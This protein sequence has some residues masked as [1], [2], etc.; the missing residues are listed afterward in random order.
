MEANKLPSVSVAVFRNGHIDWEESFGWADR[1]K[2]IKATPHTTYSLA[3]ISKSFTATGLMT[4]VAKGAVDLDQPANT[5]LGAGKIVARIGNANDA[6]VRRIADHTSGLPFHGQFFY[7][8]TEFRRPSSDETIRKF[9]QI[10][11]RPGERYHY[12]NL[13]YGILDT[14]VARRSGK[15]FASYMKQAVFDPLDLKETS[16]GLPTSPKVVVA[17]RYA[18]DGAK[19]PYY[20]TDHPGASEVFSSAHDLIRFAAFHMKAHLPEQRAILSDALID[21]MHVNSARESADS[22]YGIGFSTSTRNGYTIVSHGGSMPGV[23]TNMITIPAQGIA[24]V[25]LSNSWAEPGR[26][27][28]HQQDRRDDRA[29]LARRTAHATDAS[30]KA[31]RAAAGTGG[32]MDR[33]CGAP[34]GR[35][36]RHHDG[37]RRW[38]DHRHIRRSGAGDADEYRLCRRP[39]ERAIGHAD[40]QQGYGALSPSGPPRHQTGGEPPLW[41]GDRAGRFQEPEIRCR[42]HLL[43]RP[44][45]RPLNIAA[46]ASR[47]GSTN[48]PPIAS[49]IVATASARLG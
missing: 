10:I 34:G 20:D 8:D 31:V 1:E 36:A 37:R 17:V 21:R 39:A 35:L 16:V 33:T 30:R 47:M 42:S 48:A 6:T 24:I 18:T 9:G 23:A 40:P 7:A 14:I 44:P 43:D 32:Q 5:Y 49:I 13:G 15:S 4:L 45:T 12:S 11:S 46:I 27:R 41:R 25:V 26:E 38:I 3:S 2:Q 22:G 19:L 29:E 28:D